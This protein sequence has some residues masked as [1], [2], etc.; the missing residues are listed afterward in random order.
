MF[1]F[2][3]IFIGSNNGWS[4]NFL[5]IPLGIRI[6]ASR[7]QSSL[8]LRSFWLICLWLSALNFFCCCSM[9]P[10]QWSGKLIQDLFIVAL[11]RS[12]KWIVFYWNHC[13]L[14]FVWNFS[15]FVV[16]RRHFAPWIEIIECSFLVKNERIFVLNKRLCAVVSKY[17][18]PSLEVTAPWPLPDGRYVPPSAYL[19]A[20]LDRPPLDVSDVAWPWHRPHFV[21][22]LPRHC[23]RNA[24]AWRPMCAPP[25]RI[26]ATK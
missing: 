22:T 13:P 25:P 12:R 24:C 7:I 2:D 8:S 10:Q 21:S 4:A 3:R 19:F 15:V 9:Q 23:W 6:S 1:S 11:A 16:T 14:L 5:E 18:L 20:R 17:F 26:V